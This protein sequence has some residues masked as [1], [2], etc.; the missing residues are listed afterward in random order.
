MYKKTKH[1]L[2]RFSRHTHRVSVKVMLLNKA[3]DKVL[4]TVMSDGRYGLPGGHIDRQESPT[5]ALQRELFEE[6]GLTMGL[7]S[8]I[9]EHGF[10]RSGSRLI[11]MYTGV[12][13]ED[14]ELMPDETE[15]VDAEWVS[16]EDLTSGRIYSRTYEEHIKQLLTKE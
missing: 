3:A 10:F 4:M 2:S 16:L 15:V 12:L 5:L 14:I 9:T 13:S 11:L 7:Y 8:D 6:L 1:I